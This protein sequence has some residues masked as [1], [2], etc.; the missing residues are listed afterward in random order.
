MH[1]ERLQE[2]QKEGRKFSFIQTFS[3]VRDAAWGKL[4]MGS[5]LPCWNK[6]KTFSVSAGIYR[7]PLF[8][9]WT[10]I[11]TELLYCIAR[12]WWLI[13]STRLQFMWHPWSVPNGAQRDHMSRHRHRG[14]FEPKLM[15]SSLTPSSSAICSGDWDHEAFWHKDGWD[16]GKQMS[17][18]GLL[19]VY[20]D[21]FKKETSFFESCHTLKVQIS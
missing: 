10:K 7:P 13:Y 19:S 2:G 4:K 14:N 16:L 18:W 1:R 15:C 8:A 9:P 5:V 3:S 6:H 21:I 17:V 12:R 11:D 20:S